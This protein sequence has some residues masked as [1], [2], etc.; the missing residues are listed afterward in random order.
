MARQRLLAGK[1]LVHRWKVQF[2]DEYEYGNAQLV[3]IPFCRHQWQ[4]VH[5]I[6]GNMVDDVAQIIRDGDV[7]TNVNLKLPPLSDRS[8]NDHLNFEKTKNFQR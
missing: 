8:F 6:K 1:K 5:G 2:L 7:L 4:W 3:E